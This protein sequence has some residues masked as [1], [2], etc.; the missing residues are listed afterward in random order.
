MYPELNPF[1]PGSGLR[2]PRLA[3][4]DREI[5]A[6]DLIV[7]RSLAR[8]TDASIVLHGYR[9]VGKTVLLNAMRTQAENAGWLCIDVEAQPSDT[10]AVRLRQQLG[11]KLHEAAEQFKKGKAYSEAVRRALG[12]LTGFSLSLGVVSIETARE[13]AGHR[14]RSGVLEVDLEE[15]V[16]DF[17]DALRETGSAIGI[18]IDEMQDVDDEMLSALLTVQNRAGQKEIPFYVVG[19]GLPTLPARLSGARS[20]AERLFDYRHIGALA[21]ESAVAAIKE[22]LIRNNF[23][24]DDDALAMLTRDAKG[25]PYFLQLFGREAWNLTGSRLIDVDVASRALAS[26]YQNLDQGYFRS[27]WDRAD[28]SERRVL[29]Y[30]AAQEQLDEYGVDD[31]AENV[32]LSSQAFVGA[33]ESLTNKGVIFTSGPGRIAFTTPGMPGHVK[34]RS[35]QLG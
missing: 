17:A 12:T 27:S 16:E 31:V 3:G 21:A 10:G 25:Y 1:T 19:A 33:R 2:P 4:R 5:A 23:H 30:M 6:F 15:L 8:R 29:R 7:A 35:E 18:F 26:A 14:A 22:P 34:R 20:Y 32:G 13:P 28:A 9:G 24:I 11:R